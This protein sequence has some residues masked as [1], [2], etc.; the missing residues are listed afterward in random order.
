MT[1]EDPYFGLPNS[2]VLTTVFRGSPPDASICPVLGREWEYVKRCWSAKVEDRP[3][4]T[5]VA[6]AFGLL[7]RN[8]LYYSD[9]DLDYDSE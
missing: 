8:V 7:P 9:N 6:N 3:S 2:Q 4:A 5:G 1:G